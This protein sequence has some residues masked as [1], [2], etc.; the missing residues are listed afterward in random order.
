MIDVF[1]NYLVLF[2]I[3]FTFVFT[4]LQEKIID[5]VIS[6]ISGKWSV[7]MSKRINSFL[8]SYSRSSLE[9]DCGILRKVLIILII[10]WTLCSY[11]NI[12][13]FNY[14]IPAIILILLIVISPEMLNF[15]IQQLFS[16]K[17]YEVVIIMLVTACY[18]LYNTPNLFYASE[19]CQEQK[20]VQAVYYLVI[21]SFVIKLIPIV[22]ASVTQALVYGSKIFLMLLLRYDNPAKYIFKFVLTISS[23]YLLSLGGTTFIIWFKSVVSD[24]FAL[25]VDHCVLL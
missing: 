4:F 5:K 16:F 17:T 11:I 10:F 12:P 25:L 14:V 24:A 2:T 23:S 1:N 20:V 9:N 3:I 6:K 8:L 19:V 15:S 21:I 18:L 22:I 7:K 13:V